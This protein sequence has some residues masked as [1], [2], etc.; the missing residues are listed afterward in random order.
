MNKSGAVFPLE[1]E[2]E[3]VYSKHLGAAPW[4]WRARE[5]GN[6]SNLKLRYLNENCNQFVFVSQCV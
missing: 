4:W 3:C 1:H 2:V 6:F 5:R